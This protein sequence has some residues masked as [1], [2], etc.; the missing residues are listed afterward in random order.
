M[1]KS[2]LSQAKKGNHF[3]IC[4][5]PDEEIRYHLMRM[6]LSSGDKVTCAQRLPGGTIVLKKKRQEIAI[7]FELAKKI[8]ISFT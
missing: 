7:G 6:G 5:L 4:E 3:I 8:M 2:L 1:N